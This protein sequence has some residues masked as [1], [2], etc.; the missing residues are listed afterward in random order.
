MAAS[1]VAFARSMVRFVLML[2]LSIDA[3]QTPSPRTAA[4]RPLQH[5]SQQRNTQRSPR[6][7]TFALRSTLA[8]TV[9]SAGV[10]IDTFLPQF[11]WLPMIAFRAE[12]TKRQR[13]AAS[14]RVLAA[15]RRRPSRRDGRLPRG[16]EP[17][18]IFA[19]VFDP[20][21]SQ[22]EGMRRLFEV[23]NF[24]AEWPT[25]WSGTSSSGA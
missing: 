13:P 2:S 4:V 7:N 8:D 6:R 16:I 15:R 22:L 19:D 18:F 24:A 9:I 11:F 21:K 20:T 5:H 12:L 17:I 14:A 1:N 23:P 10:S 25:L 3:F